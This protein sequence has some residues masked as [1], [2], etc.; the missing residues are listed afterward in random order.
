MGLPQDTQ[1]LLPVPSLTLGT[2]MVTKL[3]GAGGQVVWSAPASAERV[4]SQTTATEV[5][6]V[7]HSAIAEG[8]TGLNR[9]AQLWA[10]QGASAMAGAADFNHSAWFDGYTTTGARSGSVVSV[11]LSRTSADGRVETLLQASGDGPGEGSVMA[12]PIWSDVMKALTR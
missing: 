11:V 12:G 7:L 1:D 10:A 4:L 6:D 2:A 5:T 3:V 9:D 8:T